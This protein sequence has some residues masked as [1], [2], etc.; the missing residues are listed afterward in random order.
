M[1]FAIWFV[2]LCFIGWCLN[3]LFNYLYMQMKAGNL[4]TLKVVA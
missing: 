1:Y 2:G 3:L 4:P